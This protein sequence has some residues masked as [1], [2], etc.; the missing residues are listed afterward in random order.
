MGLRSPIPNLTAL[1]RIAK[2]EGDL[3]P[4]LGQLAVRLHG[5]GVCGASAAAVAWGAP[6]PQSFLTH[7]DERPWDIQT[8]VIGDPSLWLLAPAFRAARCNVMSVAGDA[9]AAGPV[10]RGG[11]R[12]SPFW[13][14]RPNA[15]VCTPTGSSFPP[16]FWAASA[17]R[18]R[19]RPAEQFRPC[20]SWC[21]HVGALN[22]NTGG[23]PTAVAATAS[24]ACASAEE[25]ARRP[26]PGNA[27]TLDT[28]PHADSAPR[29]LRAASQSAY[30][31]SDPEQ[32]VVL[33]SRPDLSASML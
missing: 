1:A 7:S 26:G 20:R 3:T 21:P 17:A 6:R 24:P 14:V 27:S 11:G 13:R 25:G 32:R 22:P 28:R 4:I 5:L 30:P 2:H 33:D 15:P 31:T 12:L 9:S 19:N 18:T 29:K 16:A 8:P 10:P 23:R